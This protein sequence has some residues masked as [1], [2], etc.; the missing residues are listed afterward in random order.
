MLIVHS[1][2]VLSSGLP[3]SVGSIF[4]SRLST[5][6]HAAAII[7]PPSSV[8][9]TAHPK[10]RLVM[11][12]LLAVCLP[13]QIIFLA[14]VYAFG[15]LHLHIVFLVLEV[16]FFCIT[17]GHILRLPSTYAELRC[18]F[19]GSYLTQPGASSD[20]L[21][22]VTKAGSRRVRLATALG[23]HGSSRTALARCMLRSGVSVRFESAERYENLVC[24]AP[25]L[26]PQH[27]CAVNIIRTTNRMRSPYV[28]HYTINTTAVLLSSPYSFRKPKDSS[29]RC[30][31]VVL[32]PMSLSASSCQQFHFVVRRIELV[33]APS[34]EQYL[35]CFDL[36]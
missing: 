1:C 27:F 32:S 8:D 23:I 9:H 2:L 33:R 10:P 30:C 26:P 19:A 34:L 12:T 20:Q 4:V 6:L 29:S 18:G 5:A 3:G 15:W 36:R 25:C 16:L 11:A 7:H 13:I 14:T 21:L 28:I 22:M 17:V 35:S 31:D 24:R